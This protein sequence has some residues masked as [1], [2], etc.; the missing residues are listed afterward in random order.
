MIR[1]RSPSFS[2]FNQAAL[3]QGFV[4]IG[5]APYLFQFSLRWRCTPM[6][7][8][9]LTLIQVETGPRSIGRID[10]Y[11]HNYAGFEHRASRQLAQPTPGPRGATE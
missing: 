2:S 9:F 5:A 11:G 1:R 8:R 4:S 6:A 3:R 7:A 10:A